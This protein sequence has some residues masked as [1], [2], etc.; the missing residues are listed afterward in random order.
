MRENKFRAW[1]KNKNIMVYEDED[2][3]ADY[4]DGVCS[5]D[6]EMINARLN[7]EI[8]IWL[9][10]T[11]LKDKKGKEIYDS[12]IA[13]RE[14]FVFGEI[15]TFIGQVKMYE[16]CWWI[17][18]GTAAVPLWNELHQLEVIGNIYEDPQLL[19]LEE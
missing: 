18:N 14:T 17:D 8:Y 19:E 3:S 10:Y 1:N 4:W 6:I 11:G 2:N 5:S 7:S 15:R 13:K 12:D 16:G 9:Q